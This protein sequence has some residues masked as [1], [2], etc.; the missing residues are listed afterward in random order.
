[1]VRD[2]MTLQ[3]AVQVARKVITP[4]GMGGSTTTTSYTTLPYAAIW[5]SSQTKS[6]L[7]DKMARLSSHVLA[8]I[9][10]DYTF[11]AT[12]AEIIY[13]GL[14]YKIVGPSDNIMLLDE[15]TITPLELIQ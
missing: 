10:S 3:Q 11:N 1:M 15:L 7:S 8:T 6:Y 13:A 2:F 14:T 5:G 4:D 12:D 9:P